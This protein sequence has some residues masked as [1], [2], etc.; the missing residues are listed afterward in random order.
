MGDPSIRVTATAVSGA[1]SDRPFGIHHEL[2]FL[3][4]VVPLLEDINLRDDVEGYFVGEHLR[5]AGMSVAEDFARVSAI[6]PWLAYQRQNTPDRWIP[7]RAGS[8]PDRGEASTRP[9]FG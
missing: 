1:C 4:G 9:P 8:E 2:P 3:L 5:S 6:R 7:R